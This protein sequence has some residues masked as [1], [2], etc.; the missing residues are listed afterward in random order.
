M[1]ISLSKYVAITSGVGGAAAAARKDMI[2]RCMTTN[3]LVPYGVV[4]EFSGDAATALKNV[5]E[6]FGSSSNEAA[7]ASKYFAWVSPKITMATKISFARYCP[8]AIAPTII[9]TATQP[10]VAALSAIKNGSFVLNIDG[11]SYTV[12][13]LDFSGATSLADCASVIQTAI[14]GVS[15][16]PAMLT[17]ATVTYVTNVGLEF[18]GG[19]TGSAVISYATSAESGT[20]VSTLIGWSQSAMPIL[21]NGGNAETVTEA[22]NRVQNISNNFASLVF[23]ED[24]AQ[25]DVEAAAAFA[26]AQNYALV[27]IVPCNASNFSAL[28][29]ALT[30]SACVAMVYDVPNAWAEYMPAV[31]TAATPYNRVN[32]VIGHMYRQFP[33]DTPSVTTDSLSNTLDALRI[34]YLGQ[35]QQAGKNISF[36]QDGFDMAGNQLSV[37]YGEIYLKDAISTACLNLQIASPMIPASERG[38]AMF[39]SVAIPEIE[40]CLTNGVIT[41]GKP[42]TSVQQAYIDG[43]TG[44]EGSWRQVQQNGYILI[45]DVEQFDDDG[46][47]KWQ[48]AYQLI[49]SK[50]DTIVKVV[51]SDILI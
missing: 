8:E 9:P 35:T 12:E 38:D 15:G 27:Y 48:W 23:M 30:G 21:S 37:V 41:T 39:R 3:A 1:A 7:F 20:D 33:T 46:T 22:L 11:E 32:G 2:A 45:S 36:F 28:S 42:L 13:D 49:Y 6:Y 26:V 5:V 17:S 50:G 51:G 10:S 44:E 47:T 16:A 18:T 43:M 29:T 34:N 40:A 25:A 24:L 19:S 14:H 31:I 4:L